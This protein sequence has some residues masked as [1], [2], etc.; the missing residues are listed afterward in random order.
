MWFTKKQSRAVGDTTHQGFSYLDEGVLYFDSACQ[1]LR[2]YEVIAA[3]QDYYLNY[4][5]CG[6][7]V[8]YEWGVKVDEQV[9][10]ARKELLQYVKKSEKDYICSFTLNTTYGINLVLSQLPADKFKRIVTTDV[11]HN[12]VFLPAITYAKR[13]G[14]ERLLLE[15]D[16]QMNVQYKREDLKDAVV[17]LNAMTN[18][19]GQVPGNLKDLVRDTHAQGGVVIIDAAQA[20]GHAPEVLREIPFDA[21]CSS[22]HKMYGPSLGVIVV[23]KDLEA[24]MTHDWIGG[25]MVEDVEKDSF[26]LIS[27]KHELYSRFESGLQNFGGIVGLRAG[28]K[29]MKEFKLEGKKIHDH[30]HQLA[31]VLW[32]EMQDIPELTFMTDGPSGVLSFYHGEIDSHTLAMTIGHQGV[33]A[34]SGYFCCH[35]Y[36]KERKSLPPLLRLSLG[37][38]NTTDSIKRAVDIIKN[39]ISTLK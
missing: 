6:E 37:A 34:R 16:D 19:S 29:W 21:M 2:P 10:G 17:I 7:R 14:W 32:E 20:L 1:T 28:L 11:E 31:E 22:I 23:K 39:T 9:E 8:K 38:H 25:G 5:A 12:S 4:N 33:M 26:T 24:M 35:Y 3:E 15:R 18:F 30:E 27:D 13:N 36:L